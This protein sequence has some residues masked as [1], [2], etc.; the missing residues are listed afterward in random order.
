M[1]IQDEFSVS[2]IDEAQ[3]NVRYLLDDHPFR[4]VHTE[5]QVNEILPHYLAMSQAFPYLQAGSQANSILTAIK[6]NYEVPRSLEIT[7]VVGNFLSWDETGGA[8]VMDRYGKPGLSKIL[9]TEK[10]FH[11]NLLKTDIEKLTGKPVSPEFGDPT[12]S[13]LTNLFEGLASLS[14]VTRCAYMVSFEMHANTMISA[15]WDAVSSSYGVD[16][17]QL[18]YFECHVGGDDP[19][20]AYHVAMTRQMVDLLVSPE[21]EAQFVSDSLKAMQENINWCAALTELSQ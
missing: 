1:C 18:K 12:G 13:Y 10:W 2:V 16:R 3:A 19:A 5:R 8:Y 9:D 20:E 14:A 11:A 17:N 15:L 4:S 21:D 6:S 7:S